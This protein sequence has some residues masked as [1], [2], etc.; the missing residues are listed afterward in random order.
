MV[1]P[2]IPGL[3]DGLPAVLAAAREAGAERAGFVL[4]R[5]PGAVAPVFEARL[6]EALPDAAGRILHLVRE[7]RGGALYD[8]RFGVRGRGSGTYAALIGDL[9]RLAAARAGLAVGH[10]SGPIPPTFRRPAPAGQLNLF[11]D[12]GPNATG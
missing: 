11:P 12:G 5:L 3:D 4:L 9:F 8:G 1:A 6:R 2:V 7:T 10:S